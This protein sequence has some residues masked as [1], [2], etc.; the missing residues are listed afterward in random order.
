MTP[1]NWEVPLPPQAFL[2]A[3]KKLGYK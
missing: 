1:G 2:N 3:L